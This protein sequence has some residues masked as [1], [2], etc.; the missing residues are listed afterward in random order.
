[1]IQ[2]VGNNWRLYEGKILLVKRKINVILEK[3]NDIEELRKEIQKIDNKY[4]QEQQNVIDNEQNIN[5]IERKL[6][7]QLKPLKESSKQAENQ[8]ELENLQ[9]TQKDLRQLKQQVAY[10][11]Q[12][13][14]KQYDRIKNLEDDNIKLK[15]QDGYQ[16]QQSMLLLEKSENKHQF[17]YYKALFWK[18]YYYLSAMLQISTELYQANR[19]AMIESQSEK[20]LDI[21]QKVFNVGSKVVGVIP[22]GGEASQLINEALDYTIEQKKENKFKVR[23]N[24]LTNILKWYNIISP[25]ELENE[26]KV[27]A[28]ELAKKQQIDLNARNYQQFDEFVNKLSKSEKIDDNKNL[29]WKNGT[30]DA[31]V[32][33][34]YLDDQSETILETDDKKLREIFQYAIEKN[35][36]TQTEV[37]QQQNAKPI[38]QVVTVSHCCVIY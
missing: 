11:H 17:I 30:N 15:Q 20:V 27:A 6:T 23:L 22:I 1:I 19:D 12:K 38:S 28:I 24:K 18:L 25:V 14:L 7:K 21:V 16:I 3:K 37:L 34:K 9:I 5:N 4:E 31:L 10:L 2:E 29:H 8:Q 33:L 35:T 36:K 26:V 13:I 32:I